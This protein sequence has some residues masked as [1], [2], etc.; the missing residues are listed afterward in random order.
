MSSFSSKET[1]THLVN[2]TARS[3]ETRRVEEG[4]EDDN[5]GRI[6]V[7]STPHSLYLSQSEYTTM[8]I[9]VDPSLP[10]FLEDQAEFM[11]CFEYARTVDMTKSRH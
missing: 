11:F 9:R 6:F 1:F 5:L 2:A 10:W 7:G 3:G 8:T 4:N